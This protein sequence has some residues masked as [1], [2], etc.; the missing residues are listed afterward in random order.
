M[1][2]VSYKNL[3]DFV[4]YDGM[5]PKL[6]NDE[7]NVLITSWYRFLTQ[8]ASDLIEDRDYYIHKRNLFEVIQRVYKRKVYYKVFHNLKK[9][10]ELKQVAIECYWINTLKPFMVVNDKCE[11]Y[12]APNEMFSVYLILSTVR[13]LFNDIYPNET[14]TYP[15]DKRLVDMIYNFKYCDLSR[16]ATI[17]FVET[18]ADQ[19]GVGIDYILNHAE[20]NP[21]E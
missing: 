21:A 14:F 7:Y 8:N 1:I 18:F 19:Y 13:K 2:I 10:N 12:N 16:E 6:C 20:S 5:N 15:S 4:S 9:I 17:A 3:D 11:I